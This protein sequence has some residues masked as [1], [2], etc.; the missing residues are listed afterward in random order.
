MILKKCFVLFLYFYYK[1]DIV[2]KFLKKG[3]KN[4]KK[5]KSGL[6]YKKTLFSDS[7]IQG[8]REARILNQKPII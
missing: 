5:I 4:W 3:E 2:S 1:F 8:K 7:G 6:D